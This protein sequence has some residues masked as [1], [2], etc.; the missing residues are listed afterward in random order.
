MKPVIIRNE[1]TSGDPGMTWSGIIQVI[2]T[3]SAK[4][5]FSE[6]APIASSTQRIILR[7]YTSEKPV[8]ITLERAEL[9]ALLEAIQQ[10]DNELAEL[11]SWNKKRSE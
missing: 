7:H 2:F 1:P 9:N 3:P 8:T 5:T 10:N 4:G 6:M 11:P